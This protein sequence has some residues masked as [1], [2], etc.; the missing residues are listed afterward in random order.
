MNACNACDGIHMDSTGSGYKV[1]LKNVE[2]SGI[3]ELELLL[4]L[5][6]AVTSIS[7]PYSALCPRSFKLHASVDTLNFGGE[8]DGSSIVL[9]EMLSW[10]TSACH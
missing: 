9:M 8:G 1:H 2:L 6:K 4:P 7:L 5:P 3:K 10:E